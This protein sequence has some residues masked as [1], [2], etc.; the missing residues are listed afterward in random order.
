MRPTAPTPDQE[1]LNVTHKY[2]HKP[3]ARVRCPGG[4]WLKA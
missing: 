4:Q 1:G 2:R 3:A